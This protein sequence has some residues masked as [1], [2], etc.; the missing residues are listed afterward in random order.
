MRAVV[1]TEPGVVDVNWTWLPTFIGMNQALQKKI[2]DHVTPPVVGK[3]LAC[4][5]QLL[6]RLH[7]MV[8]D[9]LVQELPAVEGLREYLDGLKF[10]RYRT[11]GEGTTS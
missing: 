8:V 5:E 10:I 3:G 1:R 7:D 2:V 9:L 11:D 6:D 4:D